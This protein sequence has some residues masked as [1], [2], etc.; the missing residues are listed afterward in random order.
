MAI[1]KDG[2]LMNTEEDNKFVE[3]Y[4]SKQ[5]TINVEVEETGEIMTLPLITMPDHA[6]YIWQMDCLKHRIECPENY[7]S[8]ENVPETIEVI[9]KWC[10][11]YEKEHPEVLHTESITRRYQKHKDIMY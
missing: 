6:D 5:P 2:K 10:R 11:N 8:I 3:E 7:K 4:L 1:F 9:K